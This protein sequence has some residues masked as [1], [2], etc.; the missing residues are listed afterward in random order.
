LKGLEGSNVNANQTL[1]EEGMENG[2]MENEDPEGEKT[3]DDAKIPIPD[4]DGQA[5]GIDFHSRISP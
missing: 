5:D 4:D 1:I 3:E 2:D